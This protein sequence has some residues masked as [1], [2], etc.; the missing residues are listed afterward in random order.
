MALLK[1]K[2]IANESIAFNKLQLAAVVTEAEGISNYDNDTTLPTSAAVKDYVDTQVSASGTM[3]SFTITDGSTSET[4][5]NADTITF[6]GT[7]NEVEVAVSATDTITI[8]L[9]SDVTIT[10]DLTVNGNDLDFATGA[11]NIGASVG[12]NTLTLG[13]AT[14]TVAVANHLTVAGDLTVNGTTTT[15]NS[16]TLSVDDKNIELGSVAT[17]TDT[18]ANGGG[19]TLK[20]TTDKTFNWVSSSTSWTSSEHI[21]LASGKEFK[22]AAASVLTAAGAAKVQAAVAGDGLSHSNGALSTSGIDI[23]TWTVDA[24]ISSG[25]TITAAGANVAFPTVLGGVSAAGK[26]DLKVNGI[27]Q[28][29]GTDWS[30]VSG[31]IQWDSSD[32]SLESGD[33][34]QLVYSAV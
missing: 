8:G 7:A 25:S 11:A 26:T 17:P 30:V 4:V 3:S 22:I 13:G 12:A 1:G 24:T 18:T 2:Q 21:D 6:S 9:P 33:V 32:F 23:D 14:S 27:S 5:Q 19:V 31:N 29:H 16:T 10:G 28:I 34:I 15:I 20:G